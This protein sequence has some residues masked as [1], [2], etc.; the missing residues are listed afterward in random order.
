MFEA[1]ARGNG[2]VADIDLVIDIVGT[3]FG[4]T[5]AVLEHVTVG[6]RRGRRHIIDQRQAGRLL[7]HGFFQVAIADTDFLGGRAGEEDPRHP[8]LDG[9]GVVVARVRR[10]GLHV[11]SGDGAATEAVG[12]VGQ[13]FE[14]GGIVELALPLERHVLAP[15]GE[16]IVVAQRLIRVAVVLGLGQ[17]TGHVGTAIV[18]VEV[19][20]ELVDVGRCPVGLEDDVVDVVAVV[21]FPIAVAVHTG[22][23]QSHTHAIVGGAANERRLGVLPTAMLRGFQRGGKLSRGLFGNRPGHEV[24]HPA[25]VLRAITNRTRTAYH[26]DAVEVARGDR[27]HRQL[28]LAIGRKGCRNAVDQYGRARRQARGQA[29]HTHVQRQVTATGAVA[30]LHLHPRDAAQHVTHVH[31]AL[32][33]H[34]LAANHGTCARVVLHHGLVGI[35]QPVTDHLHIGRRQLQAAGGE[36]AGSL[37]RFHHYRVF[38]LLVGQAATL[39]QLLQ[40]LLGRQVAGHRR[41]LLAGYQFGAEEQLQVSLLAQLAQRRGQRLRLDLDCALGLFGLNVHGHGADRQGQRQSAQAWK[42]FVVVHVVETS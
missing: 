9:E 23:E 32:L 37:G 1:D 29:T 15:A 21:A 41:G 2:P 13:H 39:Q 3:G 26:V 34:R 18:V 25:D 7:A 8:W 24:D 33:F 22:I 12:V 10:Q 35:T 30:V 4:A 19:E 6:G 28:R 36:R 16:V 31:R 11:T 17:T 14:L 38:G 20:P 27:C 5:A 40:G 42:R